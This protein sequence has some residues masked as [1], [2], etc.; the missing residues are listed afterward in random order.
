MN[1]S[2]KKGKYECALEA[3]PKNA[4][5]EKFSYFPKLPPLPPLSNI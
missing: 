5:A 2:K 1:E 4:E 3:D